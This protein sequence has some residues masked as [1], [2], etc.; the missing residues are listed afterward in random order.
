MSEAAGSGEKDFRTNISSVQHQLKEIQKIL[1]AQVDDEA[2]PSGRERMEEI[3]DDYSSDNPYSRLVALQTLGVVE[4]YAVVQ[5]LS[6]GVVGCGGVGVI[7][8]DILV[9]YG[10]GMISLYDREKV[11]HS[12]LS[13][14]FFA[15]E[16]HA[17]SKTQVCRTALAN[18]NPDVRFRSFNYDI[19][20]R[21]DDFITSLRR[22]NLDESGPL[23]LVI[24]CVDNKQARL[25]VNE[26]CHE[27][28][29][30]WIC[31]QMD[32]TCLS[33]QV[34]YIAPGRTA[35]VQCVGEKSEKA[36]SVHANLPSTHAVLAGLAGTMAMQLLLKFG[37]PHSVSIDL[38]GM[39][40]TTLDS[41]PTP[42]CENELCRNRQQGIANFQ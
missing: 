9:R 4:N 35:C 13:N 19:S 25:A 30:P 40:T 16:H 39:G 36:P 41:T 12:H 6:V 8:A 42:K 22:G 15:P 28:G 3:T 10:L 29:I 11:E 21:Y 38:L 23:D 31:V 7:V 17:W 24:C 18:A 37:D 26:A 32:T 14:L 5:G 34:R 33:G 27:L 20:T 2:A 1:V